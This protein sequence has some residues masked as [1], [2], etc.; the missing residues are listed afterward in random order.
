MCIRTRCRESIIAAG[1]IRIWPSDGRGRLGVG[2]LGIVLSSAPA[3]SEGHRPSNGC[4]QPWSSVLASI[5]T[6]PAAG[7]SWPYGTVAIAA[8][9]GTRHGICLT[10]ILH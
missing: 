2:R 7:G 3:M 1:P 8:V 6:T 5:F 10:G 4:K 9:W